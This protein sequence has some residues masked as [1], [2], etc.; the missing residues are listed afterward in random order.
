MLKFKYFALCLIS[1]QLDCLYFYTQQAQSYVTKI[2]LNALSS[3]SLLSKPY[4][5]C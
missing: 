5:T 1:V 4:G 2:C 3:V